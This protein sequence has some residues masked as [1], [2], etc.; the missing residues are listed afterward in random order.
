MYG[1]VVLTC[2]PNPLNA[3]VTR[4]QSM[5][6]PLAEIKFWAILFVYVSLV[7]SVWQCIFQ[8]VFLSVYYK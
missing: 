1:Q 2:M 3:I 8:L 4:L 7:E 6:S 5:S